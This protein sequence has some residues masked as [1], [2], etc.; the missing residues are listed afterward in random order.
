MN[1]EQ[2]EN[3]MPDYLQGTLDGAAREKVRA[4][5]RDCHDCAD[6]AS[7][8]EQMGEELGAE[9][10]PSARVAQNLELMLRAFREGQ[11]STAAG[12]RGARSGRDKEPGGWSLSRLV[13]WPAFQV[14]F[15]VSCLVLGLLAGLV[16]SGSRSDSGQLMALRQ[17]MHSMR[18]LVTLSL[19]QQ[20][21]A[22]D[23]LRG[24]N[25]AESLPQSDREVRSALVQVLNFDSNVDVRLAA[26]DALHRQASSADVRRELVNSFSLQQSPLVQIAIIDVLGD[27][28]D[29]ESESFL[30]GLRNDSK[31]LPVVR[32]RAEFVLRRAE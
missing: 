21:S 6:L 19:L 2:A 1:C 20:Q 17:E 11:R 14:G 31:L 27:A 3:L 7:L 28:R 9:E 25:W 22:S 18:Q 30:R 32:Q 23:R 16:L 15:A 24:V 10:R 12:E 4:H 5:L 26:V 8:W 29:L 13:R